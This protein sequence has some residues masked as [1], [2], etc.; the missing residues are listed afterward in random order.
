MK[1]R[2]RV[3]KKPERDL[4]VPL[5]REELEKLY[6]F[7]HGLYACGRYGD[8]AEVFLLITLHDPTEPRFW[9]ARGAAEQERRE[10]EAAI[11][12][13]SFAALLDPENPWPLV[14]LGECLLLLGERE[15]AIEALERAVGR[16]GDGAEH[17]AARTRAEGFIAHAGG[18][19]G[20]AG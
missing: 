3:E 15:T 11:A 4:I 17:G 20:N 12:A 13:Y 1:T 16:A 14:H 7:G 9:F 8:A 6:S 18:R 10:I 2:R 5:S 19:H